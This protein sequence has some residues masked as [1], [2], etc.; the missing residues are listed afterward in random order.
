M[1]GKKFI[2]KARKVHGNKYD[3]SKVNYINSQTKVCII[4][5][6]HGEFWQ[7]PNSH[8]NGN[9]CPKCSGKYKYTTKEW[10]D[11]AIKI[12]G[13]K[14]DYSKVEYIN[15]HTKVCII[16]PD[17]G[18]FYMLPTS[19]IYQKQNCPKCALLN[20]SE[21]RRKTKEQ[22]I[23][24][25][26]KVHNNKYDYS[27]VDYTDCDTKVCIIC[28]EHGEFWQTPHN[29]LSSFRPQGCPKCAIIKLSK[30][31]YKLQK[32]F[33]KECYDI[34]GDKFIY[35]KVHYINST[36]K[37]II[38]CKKHGDFAIAPY[39]FL[40]YHGCPFCK[41]SIMELKCFKYFK[42]KNI[43][44]FYEKKFEWLKNKGNLRLDFYL[45][46]Y[47][48]AIE[49][50]GE[51][52]FVPKDRFGGETGLK[53]IQE[54]DKLKKELC[55]KNNLSLEYIIYNENVEKRLDEIIKKYQ[56]KTR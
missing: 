53:E 20:A 56:Y 32:N 50:Q 30:D 19:H 28:P 48:I 55:K 34:Y 22:F 52:H 12:H 8:L 3:Y 41:A 47:D 5:P 29:H 33:L 1:K 26:K 43:N 40:N 6:E 45:T 11:V 49:C 14:Y 9:G 42:E 39:N 46:D 24:E 7:R 4:C 27:K 38:T 44:Y 16:C 31:K 25:S 17:H 37:V 21:N 2:E 10:I 35:D 13:D 15:N 36:S 23:K 18:E 51:Q 54:R